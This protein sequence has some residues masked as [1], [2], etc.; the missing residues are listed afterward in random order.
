MK[1]QGADV[2]LAGSECDRKWRNLVQRFRKLSDKKKNQVAGQSIGNF[3][4]R[5][6]W[7]PMNGHQYNQILLQRTHQF[8]AGPLSKFAS[9]N[10]ARHA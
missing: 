10:D 8:H 6:K 3:T 1:T 7:Q 2:Q 9:A 5:C 4:M